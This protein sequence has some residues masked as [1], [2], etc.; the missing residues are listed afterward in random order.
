MEVSGRLST[1]ACF[2]SRYLGSL[3]IINACFCA[4]NGLSRNKLVVKGGLMQALVFSG[5]LWSQVLDNLW[6]LSYLPGVRKFAFC[7]PSDCDDVLC[8]VAGESQ[9]PSFQDSEAAFPISEKYHKCDLFSKFESSLHISNKHEKYIYTNLL[10]RQ[11]RYSGSLS[12]RL[13]HNL[14]TFDAFP[15]YVSKKVSNPS[16][17]PTLMYLISFLKEYRSWPQI[18]RGM[19]VI[20]R[21]PD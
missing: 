4:V 15:F 1:S 8:C 10:L 17:R 3:D 16:L 11:V 20:C 18:S 14:E 13:S 5:P 9:E 2:L 7:I 19:I 21:A 12:I 6:I